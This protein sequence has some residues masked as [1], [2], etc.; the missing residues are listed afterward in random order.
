MRGETITCVLNSEGSELLLLFELQCQMSF[1]ESHLIQCGGS[2]DADR[3]NMSGEKY[4]LAQQ[5]QTTNSALDLNYAIIPPGQPPPA[6]RWPGYFYQIVTVGDKKPT[7]QSL[8]TICL[9]VRRRKNV[10]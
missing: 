9:I 1:I 2:D 5:T 6:L 7:S 10:C 8:C 3:I 4:P